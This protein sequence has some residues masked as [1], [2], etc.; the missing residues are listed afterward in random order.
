[1]DVIPSAVVLILFLSLFSSGANRDSAV[2]YHSDGQQIV[3]A[4]T[5]NEEQ[6]V[7]SSGD[8]NVKS[9]DVPPPGYLEKD[10]QEAKTIY[11]YIITK[12]RSVPAY[13]AE[14]ISNTIVF[15]AK[16]KNVDPL[17]IAAL[18]DR[19]SHFNARAVSK[20]GAKGL[21]QFMDFNLK[22]MNIKDPYN[23]EENVRGTVNYI[24]GLINRWKDKAN[25]TVWGL[26]SYLEGP[27][28]VARNNGNWKAATDR[29]IN[30]IMKLYTELKQANTGN[31]LG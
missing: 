26:A 15:Y 7:I 17:L 22:G 6:T 31:K 19:E 20:H 2:A 4:N 28:A 9:V 12:R 8:S 11:N 21:G 16:E 29:Y 5:L 23:I 27:N 24:S 10:S 1:M 14:L 30:D 18:I 3:A 13:E 25:K